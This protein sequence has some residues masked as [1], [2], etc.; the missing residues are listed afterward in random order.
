MILS[1]DIAEV[2]MRQALG[3][4]ARP[5]RPGQVEGLRYAETVFAA[6]LGSDRPA[7]EFGTVALIAAW[8]DDAA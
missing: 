4:L 2:G 8:D 5:P 7:P 6:P 1:V 3:V